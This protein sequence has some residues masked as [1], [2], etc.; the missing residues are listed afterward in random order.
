MSN[1]NLSLLN[2]LPPNP[3]SQVL[4]LSETKHESPFAK[5]VPRAKHPLP[6]YLGKG[7]EFNFLHCTRLEHTQDTEKMLAAAASFGGGGA[8]PGTK[9]MKP[10]PLSWPGSLPEDVGGGGNRK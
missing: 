6:E 4:P 2:R 8:K 10:G 7:L 9:Q 5:P 3:L 1:S